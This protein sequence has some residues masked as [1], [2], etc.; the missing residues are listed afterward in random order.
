MRHLRKT[1]TRGTTR[2]CTRDPVLR[3]GRGARAAELAAVGLSAQWAGEAAVSRR[4]PAA[5][6]IF[7]E[8]AP[9]EDEISAPKDGGAG[10]RPT[11][12]HLGAQ[13]LLSRRPRRDRRTRRPHE[14]VWHGAGPMASD[15]GGGGS[16]GRRRTRWRPVA[17]RGGPAP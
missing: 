8:Q 16:G 6:S 10:Y 1:N 4:D 15:G 2:P 3:R 11:N 9:R 14:R 5:P 13:P 17:H 12:I 7:P